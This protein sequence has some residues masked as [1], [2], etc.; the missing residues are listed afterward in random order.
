MLEEGMG[1]MVA[2]QVQEPERALAAWEGPQ[3]GPLSRMQH[4][5]LA[6]PAVVKKD[7]LGSV[8]HSGRG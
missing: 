8:A 3:T 2:E 6:V 4:E 7:Q 1:Q 5:P